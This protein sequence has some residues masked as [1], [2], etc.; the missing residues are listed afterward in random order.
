M[1]AELATFPKKEVAMGRNWFDAARKYQQ[2]KHAQSQLPAEIDKATRDLEQFIAS[3][4]GSAAKTLLKA[5]GK[6]IIFGETEASGGFGAVYFMNGDGLQRSVE[7]MGMWTAYAK[8]VPKP[9]LSPITARQA[10]E[11]AVYYNKEKPSEVLE[12]LRE[13]L[14]EI[15]DSAPQ[16]PATS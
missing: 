9:N 10:V 2:A 13:K 4:E 11:A 7:A 14:N 6:H 15:A 12:W 8:E 3:N 1:Q 16:T 5:S